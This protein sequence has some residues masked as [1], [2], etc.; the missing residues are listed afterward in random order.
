MISSSSNGVRLDC[1]LEFICFNVLRC[2]YVLTI[3]C[4]GASAHN[5][6]DSGGLGF[7]VRKQCSRGKH[8]SAPLE[9]Q[10]FLIFLRCGQSALLTGVAAQLYSFFTDPT[11]YSR[12][13]N[14]H[15]AFQL[16]VFLCYASM[17]FNTS[18]TITSFMLIARLNG[19]PYRAA[20]FD[21]PPYP[22]NSRVYASRSFLLKEYGVGK[23]WVF[24]LWHC[25][26]IF[27]RSM[28]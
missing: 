14:P 3:H 16:M 23:M 19:V 12:R 20:L 27:D 4:S 8:F 24:V 21:D 17:L 10:F 25:G 11:N 28:G 1:T 15:S 2:E 7:H 9:Q 22:R 13:S 5:Q 26:W 6:I 18:A